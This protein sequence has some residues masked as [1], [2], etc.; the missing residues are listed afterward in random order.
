MQAAKICSYNGTREKGVKNTCYNVYSSNTN[1]ETIQGIY[2][3]QSDRKCTAV[4]RIFM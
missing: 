4:E 1:N 2:F 3:S